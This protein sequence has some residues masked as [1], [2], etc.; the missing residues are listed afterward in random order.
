VRIPYAEANALLADLLRAEPH[1]PIPLPPDLG[2]LSA[3]LEQAEM[4][5]RSVKMRAARDGYAGF[6]IV[7]AVRD[8][9]QGTDLVSFE[10]IAEV[11][12]RFTQ[13]GE[14]AL[15]VIGFD[16]ETLRS[17]KPQLGA[18]ANRALADALTSRLPEAVKSRLPRALIERG[19]ALLTAHLGGAAYEIL[20]STLLTRVGELTRWQVR[21]PALP[22]ARYTLRSLP[23]PGEGLEV[24]LYTTLPV[25]QGLMRPWKESKSG[26]A[27]ASSVRMRLSGGTVVELFNWGLERGYFPREYNRDLEP[28]P[29]GA[30]H[31]RLEW[32]TQAPDHPL[33][34]HILRAS[35]ECEHIQI[36]FR[37]RLEV[38]G[39]KLHITLT[40]GRIVGVEGPTLFEL[41]GM[42][43]R[44][45]SRPFEKAAS[46]ATHVRITVGNRSLDARLVDASARGEEVE[47]A[48][49]LSFAEAPARQLSESGSASDTR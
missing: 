41:G 33:K 8:R 1:V 32:N 16:G 11:V 46:A 35:G 43:K 42:F 17:V 25:A 9:E 45:A 22:L 23:A 37:P 40:D 14:D 12:P 4:V 24:D 3:A 10:L 47:L 2:S 36:A 7:L 5:V 15:L 49:S 28:T 21:L 27:G 18:D 44:L 13:S 19:A 29:G 20:R 6:E 34:L 48:L 38:D 31:P 30:Y 39:E 26:E